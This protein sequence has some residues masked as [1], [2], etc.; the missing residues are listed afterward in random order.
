V[1]SAV[2]TLFLPALVDL[3]FLKGVLKNNPPYSIEFT[4]GENFFP[5]DKTIACL[6]TL[7]KNVNLLLV[8]VG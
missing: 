8:F 4:F 2:E 7:R 5:A 3:V 6:T 1:S